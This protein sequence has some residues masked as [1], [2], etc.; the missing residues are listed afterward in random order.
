LEVACVETGRH[1]DRR[2]A[3]VGKLGEISERSSRKVV[4]VGGA[5]VSK[6][7]L[8]RADTPQR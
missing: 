4:L 8:N 7:V 1:R 5:R 3:T 2:K 6:R